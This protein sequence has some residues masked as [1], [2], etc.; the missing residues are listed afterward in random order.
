MKSAIPEPYL[1]PTLAQRARIEVAVS[2][3]LSK[4][5]LS[6]AD[7]LDLLGFARRN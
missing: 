6:K 2:R 7:Q 3:L 1:E 5:Q 4:W